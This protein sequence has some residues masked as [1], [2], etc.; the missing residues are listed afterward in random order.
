MSQMEQISV[1]HPNDK[2][3]LAEHDKQEQEQHEASTATDQNMPLLKTSAWSVLNGTLEATIKASSL[4]CKEDRGMKRTRKKH[5]YDNRWLSML[6]DDE[7]YNA[8][9]A[10]TGRNCWETLVHYTQLK[11]GGADITMGGDFFYELYAKFSKGG[12]I[13]AELKSKIAGKQNSSA[14]VRLYE[15]QCAN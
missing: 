7:M 3:E 14:Y 9:D 12:G 4:V 2:R 11:A 6:D 15:R 5:I 10:E 8:L 1:E 13:E